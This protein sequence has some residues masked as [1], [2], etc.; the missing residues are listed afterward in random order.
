M[1]EQSVMN[2]RKPSRLQITPLEILG[3]EAL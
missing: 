1:H 2:P 3:G